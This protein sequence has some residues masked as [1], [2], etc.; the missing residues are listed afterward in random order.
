[1]STSVELVKRTDARLRDPFWTD[2]TAGFDVTDACRG[3]SVDEVCFDG[4][5][6]WAGLILEAVAGPD[7]DYLDKV[8]VRWT[9]GA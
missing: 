3:E 8:R 4:R 6:N 7:L 9:G 2:E 1:M 5:W